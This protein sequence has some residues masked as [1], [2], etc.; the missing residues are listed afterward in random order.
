M[1]TVSPLCM[2]YSKTMADRHIRN[3]TVFYEPTRNG[4]KRLVATDKVQMVDESW[5]LTDKNGNFINPTL[6]VLDET[7]AKRIV[8]MFAD[9]TNEEERLRAIA[10]RKRRRRREELGL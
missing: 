10:N 9:N 7:E 5:W 2:G 6:A 3:R 8:Q 4:I 1:G